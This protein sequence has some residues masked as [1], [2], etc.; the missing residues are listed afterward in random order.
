[1]PRVRHATMPNLSCITKLPIIRHCLLT[2]RLYST[3]SE[4]AIQFVTG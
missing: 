4:E 1:M 3:L 2:T